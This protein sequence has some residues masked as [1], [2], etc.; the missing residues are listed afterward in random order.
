MKKLNLFPRI[1]LL[2]LSFSFIASTIVC[3][4]K[5]E[6]FIELLLA[7]TQPIKE[8]FFIPD[9]QVKQLLIELIKQEKQ[10]ILAAL[11]NFTE[12]DIADELIA[13]FNRGVDVQMIADVEGLRGKYERVTALYDAGIPVFLYAQYRSIMHNKYLVFADTIGDH[14]VVW[15]GSANITKA[16]LS[17]NEENV[18]V[19]N[20]DQ[21]VQKYREAFL[22]T[23]QRIRDAKKNQE[24]T[25]PY[26]SYVGNQLLVKFVSKMRS[27]RCF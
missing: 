21:L 10:Q 3:K 15:S 11:F 4:D 23:R 12:P 18:Q 2:T 26:C 19:T 8:A 25:R 16:G 20:D 14:A 7:Q 17:G 1:L 24:P 27:F 5:A 13:A 22:N 9:D 6:R